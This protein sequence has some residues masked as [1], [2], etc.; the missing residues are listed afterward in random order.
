MAERISKLTNEIIVLVREQDWKPVYTEYLRSGGTNQIT[1]DNVRDFR[2]PFGTYMII[3]TLT[4]IRVRAQTWNLRE[5]VQRTLR[6]AGLDLPIA[7]IHAPG[8]AKF[9]RV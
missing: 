8:R 2:T 5:Y 9:Y 1:V 6:Q 4:V 3:A 7:E